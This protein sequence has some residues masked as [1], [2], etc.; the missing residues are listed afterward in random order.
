M[1]WRCLLLEKWNENCPLCNSPECKIEEITGRKDWNGC[2]IVVTCNEGMRAEIH[3]SCLLYT[4]TR[5]KI[6][7]RSSECRKVKVI[8]LSDR[9]MKNLQ[10]KASSYAVG[11]FRDVYK[12][13]VQAEYTV[14]VSKKGKISIKRKNRKSAAPPAE[15]SHDRKKRY[16]LSLIHI[17]RSGASES[18]NFL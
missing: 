2:G 6:F 13:Q 3:Q 14:L 15:L 4:S 17:Y 8:S 11:A 7:P 10:K 9:W 1:E 18:W 12:R 16:I 5:R